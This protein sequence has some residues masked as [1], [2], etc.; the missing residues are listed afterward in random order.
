MWESDPTG[1]ECVTVRKAGMDEILSG[2]CAGS[3]R[4]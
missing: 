3:H 2:M 1:N 4:E